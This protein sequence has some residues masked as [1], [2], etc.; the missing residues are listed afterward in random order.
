MMYVC[1]LLTTR[2]SWSTSLQPGPGWP[3]WATV[4]SCPL[5]AAQTP[6]APRACGHLSLGPH[7][8]GKAPVCTPIPWTRLCTAHRRQAVGLLPL[9]VTT[10]AQEA[11]PRRALGDQ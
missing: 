7:R 3:G 1:I 4:P 8:G 9:P 5:V 11:A 10:A 2:L 6:V